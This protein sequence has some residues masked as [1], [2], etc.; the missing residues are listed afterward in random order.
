MIKHKK[1][2]EGDN[3]ASYLINHYKGVY[4]LRAEIDKSTNNFPRE[5]TGQFSENDVYIDCQNKVRI[6]HYG[7]RTLEAYIPSLIRGHNIIKAIQ[8]ELGHDVIYHIEET[9]SE[10]LF[11]FNSKDMEQLA[12]Y[13]KPKTNGSDR[14][15]YSTKNLV[16]TKYIIPD[17]DFIKYKS[18]VVKIPKE[19][20]LELTHMTNNFI[21]SLVTNKCTYED[22]KSDMMLKGIKGKEYIHSIGMWDKYI[23][24]LEENIS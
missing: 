1:K 23:S 4:R 5:Y 24:Y 3:I 8:T 16:K 20:I 2:R 10:V 7:N 18:I 12:V 11:R 13:L 22:I 9:D 6:Y 19:R 17:E 14:S 15:P 21:K